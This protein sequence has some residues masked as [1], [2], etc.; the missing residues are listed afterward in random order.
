MK[1]YII[2]LLLLGTLYVQTFSQNIEG[3]I[4]KKSTKETAEGVLISYLNKGNF[5]ITDSTG[6]YAFP[7]QKEGLLIIN[8][9]DQLIDSIYI[10]KSGTYDF[11]LQDITD[12]GGV[13]VESKKKDANISMFKVQPIINIS[14]K[15]FQ[16]FACCNLSDAFQG[17]SQVDISYADAVSGIKQIQLLGWDG[18]YTQ[19]TSGALPSVDGID[20]YDGLTYVPAPLVRGIQLTKGPGSVVNGFESMTGQIDYQYKSPDADEK[21]LVDYFSAGKPKNELDIS[22]RHSFSDKISSR[23]SVHL[24]HQPYFL[25]RNN[26]GFSD[27]PVENR[28]IIDNRWKLNLK[29]NWK[30]QFGINFIKTQRKAGTENT[31]NGDTLTF[32][33]NLFNNQNKKFEFWG[34]TGFVVGNEASIGIQLRHKIQQKELERFPTAKLSPFIYAMDKAQLSQNHTLLNIIFQKTLLNEKLVLK[35]GVNLFRRVDSTRTR[36]QDIFPRTLHD[37]LHQNNI[38]FFSETQYSPS[39]RTTAILGLRYDINSIFKNFLTYRFNIRHRLP[40][41]RTTLRMN[42][43]NGRRAV[44]T[45]ADYQKIFVGNRYISENLNLL[46]NQMDHSINTGISASH[47]FKLNYRDLQVNLDFYYMEFQKRYVPDFESDG[48]FNLHLTNDAGYSRS[49]QSQI[50]WDI[51]KKIDLRL[52]Y[53]YLDAKTR[54]TGEGN[55][56][57][58]NWLTPKHRIVLAYTQKLAKKWDGSIIANWN[59]KQRTPLSTKTEIPNYYVFNVNFNYRLEKMNFFF[60]SSNLFD[61][62]VDRPIANIEYSSRPDFDAGFAGGPVLGRNIYAGFRY[63]LMEKK[64][65]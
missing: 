16:K 26:D 24:H 14:E 19:I 13:K 33:D 7:F 53:R 28:L 35:K 62:K 15:E 20:A 49:L 31:L 12:L 39:K 27:I 55:A 23:L 47:L 32:S 45:I 40:N 65:K 37:T 52:G 60:G 64:E 8:Q 59:S 51:H 10:T 50:D 54:Y 3:T 57:L 42:F 1:K 11:Y 41:K 5:V 44:N 38:G 56:L 2:F 48:F 22:Y 36:Y 43:G 34:K 63:R 46:P 58:R 6:K 29:E 61:F 9:Q 30:A 4:Y 21:L 17:L 25:D 18:H